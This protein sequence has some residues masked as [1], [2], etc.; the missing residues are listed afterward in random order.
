MAE[1][2]VSREKLEL[3]AHPNADSL[4]IAKAG[5]Y[6]FVVKQGTFND[7]DSVLVVPE[8][9]I[10]PESIKAEYVNYLKGPEKNR[11]GSVRLRGEVSQGILL[12]REQL[13]SYS[14]RSLEDVADGEDVSYLL[15]INKYEPPLPSGFNGR[16]VAYPFTGEVIKHDCEQYR[17]YASQLDPEDDVLI[18]EKIH[19]SQIVMVLDS[20]G[21]FYVSSK[22][23]FSKGFVIEE[24][25]N[26]IYWQAF[27]NSGMREYMQ[28]FWNYAKVINSNPNI[29]QVFGEVVPCQ[30]G[31]DYGRAR[32]EVLVFRIVV[33][34]GEEVLYDFHQKN[35]PVVYSGKLKDANLEELCQGNSLLFGANHIREGI[36]VSPV[37]L[38]KARDGNWLILKVINPAYAKKET[39]EELS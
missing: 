23:M 35:V 33:N 37:P 25:P 7:G 36:V 9:S 27:N 24:D 11:V 32:P 4:Q 30:K 13:E 5:S 15:G 26:N 1:W 39:G 18:T 31:F 20:E 38:R 6:Q 10:L 19:G 28:N 29:L 2:K 17:I 34:G 3:F 8:K 12:T 21:K 14:G 16:V 22:G